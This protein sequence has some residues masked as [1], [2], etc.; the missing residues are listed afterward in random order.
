VLFGQVWTRTTR[1]ARYAGWPQ[2]MAVAR[3]VF[4]AQP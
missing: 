3:M 4:A 1:L 2:A